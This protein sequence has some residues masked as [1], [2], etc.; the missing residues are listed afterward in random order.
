MYRPYG[1][2]K[3]SRGRGS[4][5]KK[6]GSHSAGK[7]SMSTTTTTT[8]TTTTTTAIIITTN[9]S[10]VSSFIIATTT[11][12]NDYYYYYQAGVPPSPRPRRALRPC[13]LTSYHRNIPI[14]VV[15]LVSQ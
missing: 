12:T 9:I 6:Q 10:I 13:R 15:I 11:T 3:T 8:A 5:G 4:K 7:L 14:L 1:L 2:E